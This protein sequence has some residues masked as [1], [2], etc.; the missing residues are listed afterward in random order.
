MNRMAHM[1]T[2]IAECCE[3]HLADGVEDFAKE[4][5]ARGFLIATRDRARE[6]LYPEPPPDPKP[7][8]Y[9]PGLVPQSEGYKTHES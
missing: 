4:E 5:F 7:G 2:V 6:A 3:E 8:E 9:T 1:L